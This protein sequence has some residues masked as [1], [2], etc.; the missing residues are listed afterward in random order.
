MKYK[1][2]PSSKKWFKCSFHIENIQDSI[3][4]D[5]QPLLNTR[6]LT[7]Q[8]HDSTYFNDFIF[9]G[10]KKYILNRVIVN[11]MP[12][13]AW[14]FKCLTYLAVKILNSEVEVFS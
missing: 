7:S 13:R 4:P 12:G 5:L 14:N 6:Y 2:E 3:R 11:T 10:L 8:T 1:F 9:Y